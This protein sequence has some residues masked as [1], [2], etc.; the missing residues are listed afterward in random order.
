[1]PNEHKH[2]HRI[3]FDFSPYILEE[4]DILRDRLGAA[5]RGDVIRKALKVLVWVVSNLHHGHKILVKKANGDTYEATFPFL[6][7]PK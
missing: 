2:L 7:P 5:T 4:L 1:M 6:P 3:S